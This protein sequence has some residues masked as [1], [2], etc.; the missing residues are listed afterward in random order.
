MSAGT[1]SV[2]QNLAVRAVW[3]GC[4][5]LCLNL[6]TAQIALA[7]ALV[8]IGVALLRPGQRRLHAAVRTTAPVL[9]PTLG[10]FGA[11]V[12]SQC[13]TPVAW[14]GWEFAYRCR[15]WLA[16][17]PLA[18]ALAWGG[19]GARRVAVWAIIGGAAVASCLGVIQHFSGVHPGTELLEVPRSRWQ[20]AAPGTEGRFAAVGLFYNRT[21]FAHVIVVALALALGLLLEGRGRRTRMVAAGLALP[22]AAA[23]LLSYTRAALV[24]L[25]LALGLMLLIRRDAVSSRVR[26]AALGVAATLLVGV[27]AAPSLRTRAGSAID[28]LANQDRQFLW[29]RA[30]EIG[31]DFGATGIGFANYRHSHPYFLDRIDSTFGMRSQGHNLYLTFYVEMGA[32]GL[33]TLLWF[34][35]ASIRLGLGPRPPDGDD[36]AIRQGALLS[37]ICLALVSLFHDPIYQAVE[38]LAF[39]TGPALLAATAGNRGDAEAVPDLSR[40]MGEVSA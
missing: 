18:I 29:R 5:A 24:S 16:L 32:L 6:S 31:R 15:A 17:F 25:L 38:A 3:V 14:S 1:R 13:A 2:E 7:I 22:I 23:L 9:L 8:A 39:F 27:A 36:W 26:L 4:G 40:S 12:V 11:V 20:I 37:V 10:L 33:L 34:L 30:L 19:P 21:R 28:L 35:T